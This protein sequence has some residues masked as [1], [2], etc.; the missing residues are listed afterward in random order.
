MSH[1]S[2]IDPPPPDTVVPPY[3]F[4]QFLADVARVS[5]TGHTVHVEL[6]TSLPS[7]QAQPRAHVMLGREFARELAAALLRAA[8]PPAG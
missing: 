3:V 1:T 4:A 7:G 6:A 2:S 5:A 8:D